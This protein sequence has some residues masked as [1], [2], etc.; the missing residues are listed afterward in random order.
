[1]EE[2]ALTSKS[3]SLIMSGPNAFGNLMEV[4]RHLEFAINPPVNK[5]RL[6]FRSCALR[7]IYL[8]IR[9]AGSLHESHY[10]RRP[11]SLKGFSKVP[12]LS[13]RKF[14]RAWRLRINLNT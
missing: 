6:D 13:A 7:F 8:V 11:T 14:V 2:K 4:F 10:L 12:L 5:G 9:L 3:I 1:M